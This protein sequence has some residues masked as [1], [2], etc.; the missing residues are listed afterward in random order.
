M[1]VG[2]DKEVLLEEVVG[3]FG[4]TYIHRAFLLEE[5]KETQRGRTVGVCTFNPS[6]QEAEAG[7]SL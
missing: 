5:P 2:R 3:E 1:S 7:G 4:S 6:I